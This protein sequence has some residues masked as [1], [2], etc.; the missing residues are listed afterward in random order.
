MVLSIR[1]HELLSEQS[2]YNIIQEEYKSLIP[3]N[4]IPDRKQI[5]HK[6]MLE[7]SEKTIELKK[8]VQNI[9][10]NE[11]IIDKVENE[12]IDESE[13][14]VTNSDEEEETLQINLDNL[15]EI[16]NDNKLI[17][18]DDNKLID[19]DNKVINEGDNKLIDDDDNKLID[20]DNKV[21][22]EGDPVEKTP[23][24]E[25]M[26]DLINIIE[27]K[28]KNGKKEEKEQSVEITELNVNNQDE[29]Q[30]GNIKKIKLDHHYNFF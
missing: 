6:N 28:N 7:L 17:D 20:D 30:G 4:N 29:Q 22:N 16:D 25:L 5:Y 19:D 24:K 26:L 10:K 1:V 23:E 13:Q 18:D 8:T 3:T 9:K 21:I 12:D 15:K 27:K 14:S 2:K 11:I